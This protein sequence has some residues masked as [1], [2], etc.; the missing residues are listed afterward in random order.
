MKP[1]M[2]GGEIAG[3][4]A[5]SL[6]LLGAVVLLQ[7]VSDRNANMRKWMVGTG[8]LRLLFLF[9]MGLVWCPGAVS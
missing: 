8:M 9:G 5:I 4:I 7:I 3:K 6:G 2:T 1:D